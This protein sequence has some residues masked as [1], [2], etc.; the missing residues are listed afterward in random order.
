MKTYTLRQNVVDLAKQRIIN[1]FQNELPVTFSFSG[2]KDSITLAHLVYSLIREGKIDPKLLNVLFIDEEA[3]HEEIIRIVHDWRVKFLG[4]GAKFDWWCIPVKHFNCFNALSSDESFICWDPEKKDVW[5]RQPP[6][7]A[8]TYHPKLRPGV[9][10]YQDFLPIAYAGYIQMT[11]VRATES[12]QRLI[13]FDDYK[14]TNRQM[15]PIYDW[16]DPDV[17]RYIKENDL[18]FPET[19]LNLWQ[20][21][22]SRKDMRLSQFFSIDTARIL[23]RLSEFDPSLMERVTRREP[24][25]YIASLYWDT[26]MFRASGKAEKRAGV[27]DKK[28]YEKEIF[29]LLARPEYAFHA[30]GKKGTVKQKNAKN[31]KNIMIKFNGTLGER[32]YKTIYN[33]LVAGDPKNRTTRALISQLGAAKG[34]G[35]KF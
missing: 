11:G 22:L 9:H 12:L 30:K 35:K 33:I 24:N 31:L 15:Q 7:F 13:A 32:G 8:L 26:E 23:V 21:G 19:Y 29:E 4:V 16:R 5:V 27:T 18:D 3:M 1:A 14:N 6:E 10:S 2:G 25:A 20:L 34:N 17:W 28:D